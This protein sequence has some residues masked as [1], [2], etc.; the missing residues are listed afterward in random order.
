M[1]EETRRICNCCVEM[2][3]HDV[4]LRYVLAGGA[5]V[6]CLPETMREIVERC[7]DALEFAVSND[8]GYGFVAPP[9]PNAA[10]FVR[11]LAK[12]VMH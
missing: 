6:D 9:G 2:L 8:D 3:N 12:L 1:L 7:P 10:G 11:T 5:R 4:Y